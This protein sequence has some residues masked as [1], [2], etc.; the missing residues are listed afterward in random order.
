M[1]RNLQFS[2]SYLALEDRLLVSGTFPDRTEIRLLFTRRLTRGLLQGL[3]RLSEMLVKGDVATPEMKQQVA[4]F[5]R[6]AAVEQADFSQSYAKGQP[7]ALMAEGPRLATEITF[8]PKPGDRVAI[9]IKLDKGARID[10]ALPTSA[11][12]SLAHLLKTQAA[13]AKWDLAP[14]APEPVRAPAARG[15]LN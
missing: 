5:N 8:S 14:V 4:S 3:D 7:H 12:W 10:F 11:L 2:A 6:E 13:R 15:R 9:A 1:A